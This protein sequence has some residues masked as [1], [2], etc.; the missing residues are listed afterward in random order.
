MSHQV[1]GSG[2]RNLAEK[3]R[4]RRKK[5]GARRAE[6]ESVKEVAKGG[7]IVAIRL[8]AGAGVA[9]DVEDTL[10]ML[11]LS[12]KHSAVLVYKKPDALGMLQKVKDYVTWGEASKE[13]LNVLF[14]KRHKPHSAKKLTDR[15]LKE[16]L[17]VQS[18]SD[19]AEA[20]ERA[21][22]PL[23]RLWEAGFPQVFH[24]HPPKGG[25][26]G[27][28]KRSFADGGELGDRGP[29]IASLVYRMT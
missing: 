4:V 5:L 29:E 28:L 7:C 1:I 26:K 21:E 8:R 23:T 10:R 11:R 9:G 27:A 25:F 14:Q 13:V 24:L 20:L 15:C 19:L 3:K 17:Q 12:R 18:I 2:R 16:K 6:K 22:I